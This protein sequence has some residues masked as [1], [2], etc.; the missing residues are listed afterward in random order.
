MRSKFRSVGK[1][2]PVKD[3]ITS[4][5]VCYTK[6]LRLPEKLLEFD[7]HSFK[8]WIHTVSRNHCLM[9]IRKQKSTRRNMHEIYLEKRQELMENTDPVHLHEGEPD[10]RKLSLLPEAI[11]RLK[12]V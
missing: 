10:E 2:K 8:G 3:R 6:L 9:K 7:I 11:A 5:N 4:Y 12:I 1:T